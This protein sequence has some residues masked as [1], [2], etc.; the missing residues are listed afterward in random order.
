M[1]PAPIIHLTGEPLVLADLEARL[2][3][4]PGVGAVASFTGK[5]RANDDLSALELTRHPV[6][7][8]SALQRIGETAIDRFDLAGLLIAHRY[9]RM[10]PGEPIV[11]IVAL[12]AHRR[13]ALDAT[14]F[15]IDVLKT[16]APFWKREWRG[17]TARWVETTSADQEKAG[18]WLETGR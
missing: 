11:H 6:L 8:A 3:A 13:A 15:A 10:A 18:Q 17:E 1:M 7:T 14:A 2:P 16:E 12:A 4:D 5:V 9:G